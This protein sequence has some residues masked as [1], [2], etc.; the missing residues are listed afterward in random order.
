MEHLEKI[1]K[2]KT[3]HNSKYPLLTWQYIVFGHNENEIAEARGLAKELGMGF[4]VKLSWDSSFSPIKNPDSVRKQIG[5]GAVSREEFRQ[6]K[7][8]SYRQ[9][10][11]CSQLWTKPQVN[12]DGRILGCCVNT[13]GD[14]GNAFESGLMRSLNSERMNYAREMLLGRKPEGA[15][16][17]CTTCHFYKEMKED[18][19][20]LTM[21]DIRTLDWLEWFKNKFS[22][23]LK[24]YPLLMRWL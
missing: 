11:I 15:D 20:F 10:F 21:K 7:R 18:G 23:R 16:I 1:N 24:Y 6:K 8:K 5:H 13:W 9:K 3:L 22:M 4:L 14:F 19:S 17:P 12:W 2:F